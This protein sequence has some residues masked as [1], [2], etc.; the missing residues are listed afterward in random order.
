VFQIPTH[1]KNDIAEANPAKSQK[2]GKT[3]VSPPLST[4][5]NLL[6]NGRKKRK[7]GT[8]AARTEAVI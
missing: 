8:L 7:R 5:W 4:K 3:P 1:I 2:P 6:S